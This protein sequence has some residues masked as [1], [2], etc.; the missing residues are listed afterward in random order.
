MSFKYICPM[1]LHF[2]LLISAMMLP[3]FVLSASS[4][5]D[6][7]SGHLMLTILL[8]HLP[9]NPRTLL[10]IG[11]VVRHVSV[12]WIQQHRPYIADI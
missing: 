3:T 7:N 4:L 10:S 12:P 9:S 8:R 5:F 1:Y 2:L 11:L 6:I